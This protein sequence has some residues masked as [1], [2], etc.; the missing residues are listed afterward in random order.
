M[1]P[2]EANVAAHILASVMQNFSHGTIRFKEISTKSLSDFELMSSLFLV[3]L[4][5]LYE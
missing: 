2:R 1:V 3:K 5:Y 4:I